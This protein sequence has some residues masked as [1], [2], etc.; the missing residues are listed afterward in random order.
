MSNMKCSSIS[1][2]FST[3][4]IVMGFW[5]GL[6][7]LWGGIGCSW[8]GLSITSG[9]LLFFGVAAFFAGSMLRSIWIQVLS[10]LANGF[11]VIGFIVFFGINV[12]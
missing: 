8:P 5:S 12:L 6:L 9:V 4:A 7:V 2:A 3:L 10:V 11:A 1:A